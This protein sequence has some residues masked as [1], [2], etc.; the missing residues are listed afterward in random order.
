M[1]KHYIVH[2]HYII[3][4]EAFTSPCSTKHR[5][6]GKALTLD[7]VQKR[8]WSLANRCFMCLE[9]EETINHLLL[10]CSKIRALWELLF[11]LVGVSWLLPSSVRETLLSWH[12]SFGAKSERKCGELLLFIYFGRC[13]RR[14]ID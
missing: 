11:T 2:P 12:G 1:M 3:D 14:E 4:Y 9:K 6:Y 5:H 8:G 10:H 7:L 13:G